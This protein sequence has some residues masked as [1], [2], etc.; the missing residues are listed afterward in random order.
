MSDRIAVMRNGRFEQ[1]G[2]PEQIYDHL[3]LIHI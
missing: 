2:T 3:S 1:M